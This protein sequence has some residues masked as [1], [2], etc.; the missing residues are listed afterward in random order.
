MLSVIGRPS[1]ELRGRMISILGH[2][3]L[4]LLFPHAKQNPPIHMLVYLQLI[5]V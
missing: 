3:H 5:Y 1:V 4:F 2:E